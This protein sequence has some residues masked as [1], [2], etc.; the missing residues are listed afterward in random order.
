MQPAACGY[1]YSLC[2]AHKE[3]I[4]FD[5]AYTLFASSGTYGILQRTDNLYWAESA[6]FL[7]DEYYREKGNNHI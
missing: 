7:V 3:N 5:D 6:E 4:P 1:L 2:N